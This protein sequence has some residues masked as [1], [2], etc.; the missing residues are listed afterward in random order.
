FRDLRLLYVECCAYSNFV[1]SFLSPSSFPF[2]PLPFNMARLEN[3][4]SASEVFPE[5][6]YRVD[7]K[8]Y[9][10]GGRH[11]SFAEKTNYLNPK[12]EDIEAVSTTS[13]EFRHRDL[14]NRITFRPKDL[15]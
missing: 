4:A 9:F 6:G 10:D 11:Y 7:V 13:R 2:H 5:P 8:K 14:L 12:P 15:I 3:G 1:K